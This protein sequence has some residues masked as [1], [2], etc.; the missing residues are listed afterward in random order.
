MSRVPL[1]WAMPSASIHLSLAS[2][3]YA[4]PAASPPKLSGRS[5]SGRSTIR[6]PASWPCAT[7]PTIR[8]AIGTRSPPSISW[9]RLARWRRGFGIGMSSVPRIPPRAPLPPRRCS[10]PV[11]GRH[12]DV[13]RSCLGGYSSVIHV[14]GTVCRIGSSRRSDSRGASR[15]S[16]LIA[17]AAVVLPGLALS[18]DAF[19]PVH[20]EHRTLAGWVIEPDA[21]AHRRRRQG[22]PLLLRTGPAE[23]DWI[24]E[25]PAIAR[26]G[27]GDALTTGWFLTRRQH[28]AALT[29]PEGGSHAW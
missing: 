26:N 11:V 10:R 19:E 2:R 25:L 9:S 21:S 3:D 14:D 18:E 28:V 16:M 12:H 22:R 7:R 27:D 13:E 1:S 6:K 8:R 23:H 20:C 24:R 29:L 4:A 17:S 5:K 15:Y